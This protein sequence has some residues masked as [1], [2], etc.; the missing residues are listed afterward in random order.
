MAFE[1]S[2]EG[3]MDMPSGSTLKTRRFLRFYKADRP[4]EA[5]KIYLTSENFG[6]F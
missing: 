6:L 5:W 4:F 1:Q 2:F 3:A